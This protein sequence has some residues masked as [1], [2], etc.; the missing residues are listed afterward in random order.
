RAEVTTDYGESLAAWQLFLK[1]LEKQYPHYYRMRYAEKNLDIDRLRARM[2]EDMTLVRYVFSG[3]GLYAFVM[4]KGGH[5]LVRLETEGLSDRID[6]LREAGYDEV[7]RTTDTAHELYRMLW[8]PIEN[9]VTTKQVV[10]IPDGVLY[11]LSFEMLAPVATRTYAE[12]ARK[13]LLNRHALSYHYSLLA[14]YPT[15]DGTDMKGN[16]V[17]F[18]P[19]FS[20]KTKQEYLAV[21]KK[22]S[23]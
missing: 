16:F 10:I 7:H 2:P 4:G 14:L 8:E 3:H 21:A 22:D 9:R 23:V 6:R 20:Q 19:D 18:A 1:G 5:D 12:F 11:N 15:G 17:A 13:C